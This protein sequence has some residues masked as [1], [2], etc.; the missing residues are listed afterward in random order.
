MTYT[1]TTLFTKDHT[2][3]HRHKHTLA[4]QSTP[5]QSDIWS[6]CVTLETDIPS[7]LI[8]TEK[9]TCNLM[10]AVK[11]KCKCPYLPLPDSQAQAWVYVCMFVCI[12]V[13]P[14]HCNSI[15]MCMSVENKYVNIARR[16]IS[17]DLTLAPIFFHVVNF[18]YLPAPLVICAADKVEQLENIK[19]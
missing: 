4:T 10:H 13:Y 5:W 16:I 6:D 17:P 15:T 1:H 18:N 3:V 9:R 2:Y 11:V 8:N 19:C 12:W 7:R 14:T